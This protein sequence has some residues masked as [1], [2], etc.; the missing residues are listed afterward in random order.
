MGY[1]PWSRKGNDAATANVDMA[2]QWKGPLTQWGQ[3]VMVNH[4]ASVQKTAQP[5]SI[6][7]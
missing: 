4:N 2:Q 1:I 5:A 6:F 7:Q 3:D